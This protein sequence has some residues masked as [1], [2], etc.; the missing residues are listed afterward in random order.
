MTN[1]NSTETATGSPEFS[2][3]RFHVDKGV[4]RIVLARPG[5][6]NAI[7]P[8]MMRDLNAA[9]DIVD[10][11]AAVKAVIISGEGRTFSAGFDLKA[12][13]ARGEMD[14][15]RWRA[16]LEEDLDLILRFWNS[17]KPTIAAVH[18]Y[19]LGGAFELMLACDIVVA[20][21]SALLGAPEAKFGSGAVALL[22]PWVTGPKL[23]KEILFTGDDRL[24]S[25]RAC[26]MGIVNE[27]V[28]DG[29]L[30]VRADRMARRIVSSS[31]HAV[32]YLK[33]AINRTY[34]VMG[35]K[36]AVLQGLEIEIFLESHRNA[37]REQFD[38]IR[39]DEGLQ[40]ALAW[41]QALSD[42]G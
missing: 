18:G 30:E 42:V 15:E 4:A 19:C 11:D 41:R 5:A 22:L 35:F 6:L 33:R 25:V 17:P 40:A 21:D 28:P 9:M 20:A 14:G 31:P 27:V 8:A 1:G 39:Q 38:R 10:T 37:E 36:E 7:N 13:A 26:Q 24:T 23:A 29:D 16:V 2:T 34:D 32:K 3:I 12:A